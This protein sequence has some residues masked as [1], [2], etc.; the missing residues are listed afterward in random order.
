MAVTAAICVMAA[1]I[2]AMAETDDAIGRLLAETE[3]QRQQPQMRRGTEH[4]VVPAKRP[5]PEDERLIIDEIEMLERARAEAEARREAMRKDEDATEASRSAAVDE[6]AEQRRIAEEHERTEEQQRNDAE[7]K[8]AE[9][10]RLADERQ[11]IAEREREDAQRKVADE[12]RA[13]EAQRHAE[14]TEYARME[15]EREAEAVRID[16]ALQKARDAWLKRRNARSYEANAPDEP[17]MLPPLPPEQDRIAQE[18][19]QDIMDR[20]MANADARDADTSRFSTRVTILMVL[21][22]GNRGIRRHNKTA[23]PL[24]CGEKGCYVGA[25]AGTPAELVPRRRALGMM[26]TL[27]ERAGA[28]RHSLGCVFRDIDLVAYPAV[29]QPIDMRFLRHDRREPHILD[30]AS[31]CRLASGRLSCTPIEGADYIMWVVPERIA[32]RAGARELER[33]VTT[34]LRSLSASIAD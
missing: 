6:A 26:R 13:A 4:E 33:V 22:P 17:R 14:A 11:R 30:E 3:R 15:A 10:R 28:C 8:A 18:R 25:G 21:E 7:R 34:G 2:A 5:R 24:L 20:H 1:A 27:G 32:E 23:D 9:A 12:R 31:R 16:E 29:V 19:A